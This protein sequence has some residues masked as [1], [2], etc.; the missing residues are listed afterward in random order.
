MSDAVVFTQSDDHSVLGTAVAVETA[1]SAPLD[2]SS[3]RPRNAARAE[4]RDR[5]EWID[6]VR[7]IA[8]AGIVFIHATRVPVLEQIDHFFR[9]AVPF[10]LFASLYFQASSARRQYD[11][12][13]LRP[14][15]KYVTGRVRRLYLPF[16]AWGVI[17]L[18]ARELL[19]VVQHQPL[20]APRLDML[21]TGTEYHLWF[22]PFLLMTSCAAAVLMRALP[23]DNPRAVWP[24]IGVALAVGVLV[25]V[26]PMPSSW[27]EVF[28]NPTYAY[29]QWWRALPAGCFAV[30]FALFAALY[31]PIVERVSPTVAMTG[32][33]LAFACSLSQVF[34]GIQLIPRALSGL[35]CMLATLAPW[36]TSGRTVSTLA[37]FGR[38]SYGIYLC[39]ILVIEVIRVGV[40]RVHGSPSAAIDLLTFAIGLVGALALTSALARSPK[41]AWLN[42]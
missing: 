23:L 31:P 27:N 41:L 13:V 6:V 11:R 19:H 40:T 7:L 8:A 38:N 34:N 22:L 3:T 10:Y 25:A 18:T 14:L 30:A 26:A 42:G 35:G 1:A 29:V 9:F 28:D 33:A 17:Y 16:L 4:A 5:N 20:F 39:H 37:S 21:W 32:I 15:P 12:G 24:A 2:L 36:D